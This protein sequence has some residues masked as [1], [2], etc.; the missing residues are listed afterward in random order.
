M[1]ELIFPYAFIRESPYP[2][3]PIIVKRGALKLRTSA[4]VDSGA[5]ISVFQKN[6]AEFFGIKIEEGEKK[7]FQGVKGK[8]I[9][10][11]HK[12][13]VEVEGVE[14]PCKIAFSREMTTSLNIL[15]R[16]DFFSYF[17]IT[18][19]EINKRLKMVYLK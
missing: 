8:I 13:N 5:S 14:F 4:L 3:I 9:A 18:F 10:Y 7:I 15:G 11:V 16:D 12:L 19:D 17:L 2:I 6:I 1:N